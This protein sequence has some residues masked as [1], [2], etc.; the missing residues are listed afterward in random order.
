MAITAATLT[1]TI[2]DS[3]TLN[4]TTYGNTITKTH[5]SVKVLRQQT[6]TVP[7]SEVTLFNCAD[8]A[9]GVTFDEDNIVYCRITNT[10]TSNDLSL[11]FETTQGDEAMF[12]LIPGCTFLLNR[13]NLALEATTAGAD[14]TPGT[15]AAD[16]D[17]V[18]IT[19]IAANAAIDV[20]LLI[21]ATAND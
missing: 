2:T 9:S 1:S 4:G 8:S 14:V 13:F 3:I 21:A 10:D 19:A 7:T 18:N 12:K 20:E 17:I 15:F 6:V 11:V 5:A 16:A